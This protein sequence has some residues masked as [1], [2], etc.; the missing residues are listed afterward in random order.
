MTSLQ[1]LL[2]IAIPVTAAGVLNSSNN[3]QAPKLPHLS[4]LKVK[5]NLLEG[6]YPVFS[7][8]KG[9]MYAGMLP[10][11]LINDE[12]S[13]STDFSSYMFWLFQPDPETTVEV[14]VVMPFDI[15]VYTRH[16]SIAQ[17]YPV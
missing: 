10:A 17:S 3:M 12:T 5:R 8:F 16:S 9:D 7:T 13:S 15:C 4:D 14:S 2:L 1:L 6:V 11:V